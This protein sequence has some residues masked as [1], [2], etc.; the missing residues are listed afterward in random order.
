MESCWITRPC[1]RALTAGGR[2]DTRRLLGLASKTQAL[3]WLG[4]HSQRY[5]P[6][7]EEV[8]V[9]TREGQRYGRE[10][11]SLEGSMA[12]LA[13]LGVERYGPANEF[14]S[15]ARHGLSEEVTHGWQTSL[16]RNM[17]PRATR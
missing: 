6:Q 9:F 2:R 5:P 4:R 17:L 11:G 8:S 7:S 13:I 3:E 10:E 15:T 12:S 16:S 14:P 1:V